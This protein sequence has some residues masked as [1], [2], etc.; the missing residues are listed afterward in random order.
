MEFS[1]LS[2]VIPA[3]NEEN[4]IVD[5]MQRV[6][7]VRPALQA[8]GIPELELIVVDDGSRDR[9]AEIVRSQPE[10]RLIQ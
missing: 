5:I 7:A 8:A 6:L 2:V 1:S 9:T 3:F 4:G 10:V